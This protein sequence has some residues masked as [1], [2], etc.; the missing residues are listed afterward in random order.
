MNRL[1]PMEQMEDELCPDCQASHDQGVC[2][3]E[4]LWPDYATN[5]IG[6]PLSAM[7]GEKIWVPK[8]DN[9][10]EIHNP[11]VYCQ[12]FCE[13]IAEHAARMSSLN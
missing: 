12:A 3:A 11:E 6:N 9:A 5:F 2:D 7:I 8:P 13:T 1:I 10:D 4:R